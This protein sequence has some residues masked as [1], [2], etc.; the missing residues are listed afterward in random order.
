MPDE[1]QYALL[2][3]IRVVELATMVFAPSAAVV[4]ADFGAE[5]IKVEP[6]GSGDLN[7]HYHTLPGLPDAE[8][9]Y[10]F[11]IDN[12]NK[13]SIALDLKTAAGYEVLR[14]LIA[15]ADVFISN[16]RLNALTRLKL[17]YED[18]KEINPR[19]IYALGTGWGSAGEEREKPGYDNVCYWTRS[20]IESHIFPYEGWLGAFPFGAGDHPSGMSLF[21]AIMAGLYRR[22]Q[23][24]AGGKV[25]TSLLANGAWANATMLQAQLANATFKAKRPR[26]QA[27][28]FTYLHYRSR[29][30][31]LF[32]LG[33]VNTRK[34]WQPFCQLLGRA[35]L[36]DD[37]RFSSEDA[38]VEHMAV[39]IS[40]ID[41][42]FQQQDMSH[43]QAV[44][45][46]SDI[47]FAVVP[48]YE[49]AANDP[50]KLANDIVVPLEHPRFGPLR[51]VNSPIEIS[52]AAKRRAGAAPELGEHSHDVL[53]GLGYSQSQIKQ[54]LKDGVVEYPAVF[55]DE[56]RS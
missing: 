5:V 51:T 36:A 4:M 7:R 13:K 38:R 22:Q 34:D 10:T 46:A 39:L 50:Q 49:E 25:S 54:L 17:D 14:K 31:R 3:D 40:I 48:T 12:R 30:N 20:A 41:E 21:A 45:G 32:K 55:D 16:Y 18:L 37:P 56:S 42:I 24:G 27:Y 53:S 19:L 15:T 11:Q 1:K 44:F 26:E 2:G 43:W 6:P 35:E 28:N 9:P 23:T 47:P 33:M 52:G 29:D 8:L